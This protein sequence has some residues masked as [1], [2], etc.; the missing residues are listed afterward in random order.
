MRPDVSL[1]VA[2]YNGAAEIEETLAAV[3]AY[4]DKQPY[5]HEVVVVNDGSTDGTR[6]V[7]AAIARDYP[8]LRVLDNAAN[9]GKG[10]SIRRGV[11]AAT[12]RFVFFTDADL[13][14][15]IDGLPTLLQPLWEGTHA[16]AVGSR[17]HASSVI[18]LHPR[19]YRYIYNRHLMSRLFNWLARA[20]LGLRVMD[21]QC[22]FK[23][24]E[25]EAAR[26]IFSRVRTSGFAFDVEVLLIAERLGLP[27]VEVPV[28][29]AYRGEVS[30]V[31]IAHH[32]A[33]AL[34]DLVKVALWA[35]RGDYR[36]P[37]P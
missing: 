1:V 14:Y 34:R 11:L 8:Q 28:I 37:P 33:E 16:V 21:T 32:A 23:G 3:R 35:R 18:H 10:A 5:P 2:A 12:G 4:F 13:A 9:V 7:L 36:R 24:F 19:Y 20:S 25:A 30:T 29:C 6:A 15:P 17:V 22:G 26:A 31:R 27:L